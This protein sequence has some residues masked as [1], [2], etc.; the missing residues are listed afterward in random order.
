MSL[1]DSKPGTGKNKTL[2]NILLWGGAVLAIA[3][4]WW[5]NWIRALV[6][7]TMPF[8]N[9]P[10][11][12]TPLIS[13]LGY[14]ILWVACILVVGLKRS[15]SD[16]KAPSWVGLASVVVVMAS[17]VLAQLAALTIAILLLF[18]IGSFLATLFIYWTMAKVVEVKRMTKRTVWLFNLV[19]LIFGLTAALVGQPSDKALWF[20]YGMA[21]IYTLSWLIIAISVLPSHYRYMMEK[22]KMNS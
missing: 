5:P 7:S 11:F 20:T 12:R 17:S 22:R 14:V 10:A 9:L 8:L 13:Y 21:V 1:L 6:G 3:G 15:A 18:T 4:L 2:I 19:A 16:F